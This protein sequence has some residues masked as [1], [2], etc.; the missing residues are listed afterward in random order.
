MYLSPLSF[1]N[2]Y[3]NQALF[4]RIVNLKYLDSLKTSQSSLKMSFFCLA[5]CLYTFISSAFDKKQPFCYLLSPFCMEWKV[6]YVYVQILF[7]YLSMNKVLFIWRA[8]SSPIISIFQLRLPSTSVMF[9]RTN[10][11]DTSD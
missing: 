11:I 9:L 1:I 2:I 10:W 6:N 8:F 5:K 4:S 7:F 3:V